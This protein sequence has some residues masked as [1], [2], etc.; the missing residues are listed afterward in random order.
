M[1]VITMNYKWFDATWYRTD[2]SW[3]RRG[4]PYN[5][6]EWR[7]ETNAVVICSEIPDGDDAE[8]VVDLDGRDDVPV[9]VGSSSNKTTLSD[10]KIMA[11]AEI[12]SSADKG[13]T[14]AE[15]AY[16]KMTMPFIPAGAWKHVKQVLKLDL[17]KDFAQRRN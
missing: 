3:T 12:A 6:H 15:L 1:T 16:S 9:D 14:A 10:A 5:R 8:N 13:L 17:P 4:Y 11:K 2:Y 7:S